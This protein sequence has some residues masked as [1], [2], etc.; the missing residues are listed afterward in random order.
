MNTS[1]RKVSLGRPLNRSQ[2]GERLLNDSQR[3]YQ[4]PVFTNLNQKLNKNTANTTPFKMTPA[5]AKTLYQKQSPGTLYGKK[6]PQ[7]NRNFA[8]ALSKSTTSKLNE[9][10]AQSDAF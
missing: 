10:A 6:S 1:Y 3:T 2:D 5:I 8:S 9:Q 4:Q 7:G